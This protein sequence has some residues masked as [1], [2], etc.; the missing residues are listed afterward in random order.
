MEIDLA[1]CASVNSLGI[2]FLIYLRRRLLA[3]DRRLVLIGVPQSLL[4]MLQM[5]SLDTSFDIRAVAPLHQVDQPQDCRHSRESDDAIERA[6]GAQVSNYVVED[7]EL[8][9]WGK[10]T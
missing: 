8:S 9:A 2:A 10:D 5:I 7:T 6:M 4:K 3:Q 1:Q